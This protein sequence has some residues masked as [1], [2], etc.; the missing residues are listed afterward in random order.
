MTQPRPRRTGGKWYA[1][2]RVLAPSTPSGE[3]FG[4]H[5]INTGPLGL[6]PT[7]ISSV[8]AFGT[9]LVTYPQAIESAAIPSAEVFGS[10]AIGQTLNLTGIPSPEDF[11]IP[12]MQLG[13]VVVAATGAASAEAFGTSVIGRSVASP[14]I[15]SAEAVGQP[16]VGRGIGASG[17][18]SAE[19]FGTHV[20][21][22]G[23]VSVA[24]SGIPSAEGLGTAV[25]TQP[26]SVVY[27]AVGVGTE[28]T[29]T[30]TQCTINPVAGSD[31]LAFYS[32]GG[33]GVSGMTYGASNLPMTCVGQ[34]FSSG[35]VIAAYLIRGVPAGSATINVNKVGNNWGQAV[36]VSYAGAQGY[37]PAKQI[38]GN[39]TSFSQPVAVPLNGRVIHAFTPGES[40]TTLSGL[41][42]GTSRYLD[43]AGFLTQSV[44]DTDVNA[45]F[46]G[47]LSA[48][49]NWAAL[50]TPLRAVALTGPTFRYSSG[51]AS[52][53]NN[54]TRTFDVVAAVGDY[55][56]SVVGQD[57]SGN[58]SSATCGGAAMTLIDTQAW[59]SSSGTGYIKVY[60]SAA[61][62]VS[63]GAKTISITATGG[64]W[65]RAAGLAVSGVTN[66]SGIAT[67]T[68]GTSSQPT[69]AVTCLANRL[70]LQA[71]VTA[72]APT[73]TEGGAALFLSPS[74]G[75]FFLVLNVA[76][77]STTFKLANTSVNWGAMALVL[78]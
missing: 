29:A 66:P 45:T 3:A 27:D 44:R 1:R 2:F 57:R 39:G 69:Q 64:G 59:T 47:T 4:T 74:A 43:N 58:P 34:A 8:E 46:A 38:V 53:G 7:A 50:A 42:G 18:A 62:M 35:V 56:Y 75:L 55:I 52:E 36:A 20:V 48:T 10:V 51:T 61:A 71:F 6:W 70:I 17:I 19:T 67:K 41:T 77:E 26:A 15:P 76:D 30:P 65:W 24:L 54:D 25:I 21:A 37:G 72:T 78:S 14:S 11:G 33:G 16:I 73:G 63:A 31:V 49:R 40:S 12:T 68:A 23:A 28:T 60:R 13:A 32:V 5:T 22:R 9:P